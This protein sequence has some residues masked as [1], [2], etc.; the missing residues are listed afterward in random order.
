MEPLLYIINNHSTLDHSLVVSDLNPKDRQNYNSAA[1]IS[2]D[3]TL[4]LLENIPHSLGINIYLQKKNTNILDR[5]YHAWTSIFIFRLWCLWTRSI[6]KKNLDLILSQV[7]NLDET[8]I[9]TQS[10]T[11]RQ[12]FIT[13]QAHCLVYIAT[14]VSE[15]QLPNA[16]L[17]IWLQNSPTCEGTFRSA[18]AISSVFSAGVNFTVSQFLN[19]INK[20]STLQGIK[21]NTNQNNLPFSQHHKLPKTSIGISNSSNATTLSKIAIENSVIQAYKYVAKLF[22]SLKVKEILRRGRIMSIEEISRMI[23][24]ELDKFWSSDIN[25]FND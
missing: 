1:K 6:D 7:S 25:V 12:Y 19:R 22:S 10:Q 13:N 18:R 20:L 21:S 24:Q 23:A 3:N 4:T 8:S 16:A 2:S 5:I 9:N 17:N 14:L 11:K 15:G